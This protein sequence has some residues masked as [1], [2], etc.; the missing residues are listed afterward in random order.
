GRRRRGVRRDA[1]NRRNEPVA[2]TWHRRDDG[3]PA[4]TEGLPDLAHAMRQRFVG[5]DDVRPN[6]L[7]QLLFR[8]WPI[9][10]LHEIAQH[11]EALRT[12]LN[13]PIC[14]AQRPARSI[15][16]KALELEHLE[17]CKLMKIIS[18]DYNFFQRNYRA[19]SGLELPLTP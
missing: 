2:D 12:K 15:Q 14:G 16:R 5:H 13:C 7:G 17:S 11:F 19:L 9:G 4:V 18:R 10:I 8:D 6:R 3:L 1:Q